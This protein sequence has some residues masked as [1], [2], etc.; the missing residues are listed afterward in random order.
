MKLSDEAAEA[1]GKACFAFWRDLT[2][3]VPAS[4]IDD[5]WVNKLN[6]DARNTWIEC[7]IRAVEASRTALKEA[8]HGR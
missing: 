2:R 1:A 6:Q 8:E 4:E 3:T 5:A 7:G